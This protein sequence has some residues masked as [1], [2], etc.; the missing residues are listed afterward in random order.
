MPWWI[1]VSQGFYNLSKGIVWDG[2][3][4]GDLRGLANLFGYFGQGWLEDGKIFDLET[5][6]ETWAG[7]GMLA[8]A[9]A[10][11][12]SM[13]HALDGVVELPGRLERL[14]ILQSAGLGFIGVETGKENI[15]RGAGEGAYNVLSSLVPPAKIGTLGKLAAG[16]AKAATLVKLADAA[17]HLSDAGRAARLVRLTSRLDDVINVLREQKAAL[18]VGPDLVRS[19]LAP[20]DLRSHRAAINA[21]DDER[22]ARTF[23]DARVGADHPRSAGPEGPAEQPTSAGARTPG[24]VPRVAGSPGDAGSPATEPALAGARGRDAAEHGAADGVRL[25]SGGGSWIDDA[26]SRYGG[27]S[28]ELPGDMEVGHRDPDDAVSRKPEAAVSDDPGHRIGEQP[29][30]PASAPSAP[31]PL[32]NP[33]A[34]SL[35]P[36]GTEWQPV[37]LEDVRPLRQLKPEEYTRGPDGLIDTVRGRPVEKFLRDLTYR[38]TRAYRYLQFHEPRIPR[39]RVG[40]V[41]SV[42]LD[43]LTGRLYEGTNKI[44]VETPKDLHPLLQVKV[45]ALLAFEKAHPRAYRY[46]N[47]DKS[48]KGYGGLPHASDPGTHA[49]VQAANRALYDREAMGYEVTEETLGEFIVDNRFPYGRLAR[50]RAP[51]CPN[52]TAILGDLIKSLA[53]KRSVDEFRW[54]P[55]HE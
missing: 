27:R 16:A 54:D 25:S 20:D 10:G 9:L 36:D 3:I 55:A 11:N 24:D 42:L 21:F 26:P 14:A 47:P 17:G 51:C 39:S 44:A 53:K 4:N 2:V 52:C 15:P 23:D 37:A 43:R 31:E 7:L 19:I 33:D 1:D 29:D 46:L 30:T 45:D 18:P 48:V 13:R 12:E 40:S 8:W 38:R 22:Y 50:K 34:R 35:A 5:A 49:E 6:K 41:N 32:I 28:G